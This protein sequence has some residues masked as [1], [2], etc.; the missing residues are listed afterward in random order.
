MHSN[1]PSS[2]SMPLQQETKKLII[3]TNRTIVKNIITTLDNYIKNTPLDFVVN[4]INPQLTALQGMDERTKVFFKKMIE[5]VGEELSPIPSLAE[6]LAMLMIR[7]EDPNVVNNLVTGFSIQ[8]V[9][10]LIE[11]LDKINPSIVNEI[12]KSPQELSTLLKA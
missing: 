6:S 3:E 4:A 9:K 2:S 8:P 12:N 1:T 11:T 5:W 7:T 10:K